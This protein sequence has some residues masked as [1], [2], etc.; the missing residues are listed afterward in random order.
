MRSPFWR[1]F[2]VNLL[3]VR[4]QYARPPKMRAITARL[5][6]SLAGTRTVSKVHS[7]NLPTGVMSSWRFMRSL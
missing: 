5:M 2:A 1:A 3:C 6:G 4:S 7:T